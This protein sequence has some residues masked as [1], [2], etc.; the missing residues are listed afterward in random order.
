MAHFRSKNI[1]THS[2]RLVPRKFIR[3]LRSWSVAH[4]DTIS[5]DCLNPTNENSQPK[6]TSSVCLASWLYNMFIWC[7]N[8]G[9]DAEFCGNQNLNQPSSLTPSWSMWPTSC[10][11]LK[12]QIRGAI[13]LIMFGEEK[14]VKFVSFCFSSTLG[15][16]QVLLFFKTKIVLLFFSLY[17]KKTSKQRRKGTK[18]TVLEQS[19]VYIKLTA[20]TSQTSGLSDEPNSPK[21]VNKVSRFVLEV[22]TTCPRGVFTTRPQKDKKKNP[23]AS[24]GRFELL[25][26][27]HKKK[28]RTN[29]GSIVSRGCRS[30]CI[31]HT[32][33]P[34]VCFICFVDTLTRWA[35]DIS[36]LHL[37]SCIIIWQC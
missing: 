20:S 28:K 18:S 22:I 36:E 2:E 7:I 6:T 15:P 11:C 24:I 34:F 25:Y 33:L 13:R 14:G 37:C 27:A 9:Q 26:S 4:G 8:A 23:R 30:V 21:A 1:L 12:W 16:S 19:P 3:F 10:Y 32:R 29:C 35:H 17:I 5:W 31:F